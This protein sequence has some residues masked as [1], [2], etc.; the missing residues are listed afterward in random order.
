MPERNLDVIFTNNI[1]HFSAVTS[2]R[3]ISSQELSREAEAQATTE[4]EMLD[5]LREI[6]KLLTPPSTPAAKGF[7]NEFIAFL[8]NYKVLGLAVAFI[9]GLYLGNVVKALVT[10]FILPIIS[11]ALPPGTNLNTYMIGPFG[12]GDFLN[13]LITFIIVALVI[14]LIVKIAN[15]WG[16]DK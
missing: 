5:E 10:D 14:F 1:I 9:M 12:V 16:L 4:S 8:R 2:S 13:N 15:R 3:R 6:R 11:Y 7:K